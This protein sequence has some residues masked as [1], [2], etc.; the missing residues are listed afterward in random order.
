MKN[1]CEKNNLIFSTV[2]KMFKFM[3]GICFK[4]MSFNIHCCCTVLVLFM[5]CKIQCQE[6]LKLEK[7]MSCTHWCLLYRL[8]FFISTVY[9][10]KERSE[11][12]KTSTHDL[13]IEHFSINIDSA[14]SSWQVLGA[15]TKAKKWHLLNTL[16]I[17]IQQLVSIGTL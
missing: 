5:T 8:F 7:L 16:E 4:F 9:Q 12:E 15:G 2:E 6:N 13:M 1:W 10:H 14:P 11:G 3:V 17:W